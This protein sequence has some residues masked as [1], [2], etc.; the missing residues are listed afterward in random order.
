MPGYNP[1]VFADR[2]GGSDWSVHMDPWQNAMGNWNNDRFQEMPIP[3][4]T[5]WHHYAI[6]FNTGLV[7]M[8]WDG[9]SLG[10]FAQAI[11]LFSGLTTQI[12]SASP[13]KTT[14]DGWAVSM[15]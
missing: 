10:T 15:R 14:A 3:S 6:V 2:N 4:T 13:T 7:S 11:N 1:T 9:Q 12:G 5:G 8:Y